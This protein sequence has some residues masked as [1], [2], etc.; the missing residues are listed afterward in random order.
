MFNFN[1]TELMKLQAYNE[2]KKQDP[3]LDVEQIKFYNSLY[4]KEDLSAYIITKK[5]RNIT[6]DNVKAERKNHI[7][8][9][10]SQ[11]KS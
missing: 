7:L 10:L 3:R 5:P 6:S 1:D 11:H 4:R 2:A 8:D 9:Y